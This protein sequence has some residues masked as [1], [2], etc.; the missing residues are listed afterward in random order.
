MDK[1]LIIESL[2][3]LTDDEL[4][5]A[6]FDQ[7]QE[8]LAI[9]SRCR[10]I[11]VHVLRN[12]DLLLEVPDSTP[13]AFPDFSAQ[14]HQFTQVGRKLEH[15]AKQKLLRWVGWSSA[16]AAGLLL[17]LFLG[18]QA[19]TVRKIAILEKNMA[20]IIYTDTP[21]W[22]DR[23]ALKESAHL[24]EEANSNI[25]PTPFNLARINRDRVVGKPDK[26]SDLSHYGTRMLARHPF[27][28][29]VFIIHSKTVSR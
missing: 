22:V 12:R 9:C 16:V 2:I 24:L 8:H 4:S 28:Y 23:W 1:C 10:E 27:F 18:E 13:V 17:I 20:G 21:R 5:Q 25:H 19:Q 29:N 11:R 3:Y 14:A 7:L 26:T 15:P 6:E